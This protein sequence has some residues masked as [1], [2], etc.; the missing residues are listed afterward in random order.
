[1]R[2]GYVANLVSRNAVLGACPWPQALCLA[3]KDLAPDDVTFNA[4]MNGCGKGGEWRR[5]LRVL[6]EMTE[7][8]TEWDVI[9]KGT[10]MSAC[11][12]GWQW[13]KALLLL[14][15]VQISFNSITVNAAVSA[16]ANGVKWP[17]ALELQG[18]GRDW[19]TRS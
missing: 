19:T 6:S 3:Q 8:S 11:E 14:R 17:L 13:E 12:R 18:H 7:S 16:C 4:L 10:A 2:S 9:S 15:H 1:M 5:A